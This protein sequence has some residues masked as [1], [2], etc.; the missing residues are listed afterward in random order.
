[1]LHQT[2][3]TVLAS[4]PNCSDAIM[5]GLLSFAMND[6][7]FRDFYTAISSP[8]S[9]SFKA[10]S[11]SRLSNPIALVCMMRLCVTSSAR[12]SA[13]ISLKIVEKVSFA[14]RRNAGLMCQAGAY[15][16]LIEM[17]GPFINELPL[18]RK[19]LSRFLEMGLPSADAHNLV[20]SV[21]KCE[22]EDSSSFKVDPG[23]LEDLKLGMRSAGKWPEFIHCLWGH[24]SGPERYPP[25]EHPTSWQVVP[26]EY[27]TDVHGMYMSRYVDMD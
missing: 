24:A 11:W 1:M 19:L 5:G 7:S 18:I 17:K 2:L 8:G 13:S 9:D 6:T 10:H 22:G 4:Y 26:R 16:A 21:I 25:R 23:V 3:D 12:T 27:G 20:K 15:S 14:S